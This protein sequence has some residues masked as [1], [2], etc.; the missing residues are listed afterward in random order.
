MNKIDKKS[1]CD[2]VVSAEILGRVV[3]YRLYLKDDEF[4][5]RVEY[6]GEYAVSSLGSEEEIARRRFA[7]VSEGL[8]TPCA[9]CYIVED[10]NR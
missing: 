9:L 4:Y 7:L 3:R 10:F 8:V 2:E 6:D 5:V 1:G